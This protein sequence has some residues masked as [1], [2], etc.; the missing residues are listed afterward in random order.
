MSIAPSSSGLYGD[1]HIELEDHALDGAKFDALSYTWGPSTLKEEQECAL[2]IF[3][4]VKLCY[5]IL[6]RSKI[7]LVTKSLRDSLRRLRALEHDAQFE[8]GYKRRKL[9]LTWADGVCI[10]QNDKKEKAQ[11]VLLMSRIYSESNLTFAYL[12]ECLG[13]DANSVQNA[14][15]VGSELRRMIEDGDSRCSQQEGNETWEQRDKKLFRASHWWNWA[16]FLSRSWFQRTWVLQEI[17]LSGQEKCFVLCGPELDYLSTLMWGVFAAR[18]KRWTTPLQRLLLDTVDEN[19]TYQIYLPRIKDW[20]RRTHILAWI[21]QIWRVDPQPS[22][23]S[24]T[25]SLLPQTTCFDPKDKIYGTLG[26]I[27]DWRD[28]D[29][30]ILPVDYLL[31]T[32]D[33]FCRATKHVLSRSKNLDI[34]CSVPRRTDDTTTLR[35]PSWCPDYQQADP[36]PDTLMAAHATQ[37]SFCTASGS[38]TNNFRDFALGVLL[39]SL[40]VRGCFCEILEEHSPMLASPASVDTKSLLKLLLANVQYCGRAGM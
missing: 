11:Q 21:G 33:V 2:Q 9:P 38:D 24:V 17:I 12:G 31:P 8:C 22:L 16:I 37:D 34:V 10:N 23:L 28:L 5:P 39:T 6:C 15:E 19:P 14:M 27:A 25:R 29:Q 4:A 20:M 7:V 26:F 32:T 40:L 18:V 1:L 36:Q 35:L 13:E 3:T 30:S